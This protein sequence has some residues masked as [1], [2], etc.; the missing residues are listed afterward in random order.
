MIHNQSSPIILAFILILSAACETVVDVDIPNAPPRLVVEAYLQADSAVAVSLTQSQSIL[1]NRELS[2]VSGATVTLLEDGAT[3]ATLKVNGNEGIYQTDYT[4]IVGREYTI[5]ASKAGFEPVEATTLIR[6]PVAIDAVEIDTTHHTDEYYELDTLITEERIEI[7]EVR[8]TFSDPRDISNYYQI[9]VYYYDDQVI[10][11]PDGE[12]GF[13]AVDTVRGLY[14]VSLESDDPVFS[15]GGDDFLEGDDFSAG[16]LS[17]FS[18]DFFNGKTYTIRLNSPN[19][20]D[21]FFFS[22]SRIPKGE[23]IYVM[24]VSVDEGQYQYSRSVDLQY[25]N[26]GNPFAEPVQVYSNVENGFGI[27]SGSSADQVVI[28]FE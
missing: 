16:G 21:G 27:V 17:L 7:E 8:L 14:G 1:T 3:V 5:R 13:V 26:D 15:D 11:E 4:T 9:F 28:D 10:I 20:S 12:G 24:L 23:E 2:F 18:D 19:S 25:E 22:G 6:P